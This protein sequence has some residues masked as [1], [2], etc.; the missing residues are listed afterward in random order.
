MGGRG[1]ARS[2]LRSS[3]DGTQARHQLAGHMFGSSF[4]PDREKAAA[5]HDFAYNSR[6]LIST[7]FDKGVLKADVL[8]ELGELFA[9]AVK[10]DG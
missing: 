1:L 6:T 2:W 4:L 9:T 8:R 7:A 5:A 10:N 3:D